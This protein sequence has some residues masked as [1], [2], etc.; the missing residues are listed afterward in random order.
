MDDF[1]TCKI[2]LV[3]QFDL[4]RLRHKPWK[5]FDNFDVYGHFASLPLRVTK[6]LNK[7]NCEDHSIRYPLNYIS[8]STQPTVKPQA[9]FGKNLTLGETMQ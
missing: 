3:F 6:T 2:V 5:I 4:K 7:K 9:G 8:F 1:S